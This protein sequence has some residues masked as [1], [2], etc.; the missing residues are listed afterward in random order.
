MAQPDMMRGLCPKCK[1]QLEIPA[2]LQEFSCLYC[3]A[4]LTAEDL[5]PL[6]AP[7]QPQAAAPASDSAAYFHD[8][9]L[10]AIS[11]YQG[12]ENKMTKQTFFPAFEDFEKGTR[13]T[14]V[15]LDLAV[16]TGVLTVEAAA[17]DFLAQLEQRWDE[18][19][20][21]KTGRNAMMETDKFILAIF[22]IPMIR[23][24]KLSV[25]EDYCKAVHS[26]W[27]KRYPKNP[28][29]IGNY[30]E[31]AGGFNKKYLGLCFITTAVCRHDHKPDDCAELTAF[32]SFRDGFLR[33]C[34]DG[35]DLIEEYYDVAPAIVLH[36]ELSQ[37]REAVYDNIRDQYL[38]PCYED[39][40]QGRLHQ[41]K[42]RYTTMV[43][44]LE[45]EYLS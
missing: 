31:L 38:V 40:R 44:T 26:L 24:L 19:C 21:R 13:E 14:Y 42:E 36:I 20:P 30:D 16:S 8:H 35:P 17:A 9:V 22:L 23:K 6:D 29:Q 39:I 7:A 41:C 33:S 5:L 4:R 45:Q 43:R 1:E 27:M 2:K 10:E 15:Q 28:F 12:I 32:R 34:P 18:K 25:S 37:N 3:G 11:N